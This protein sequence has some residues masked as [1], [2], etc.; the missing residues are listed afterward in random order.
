MEQMR[1]DLDE[2]MSA[3]RNMDGAMLYMSQRVA[4]NEVCFQ[5]VQDSG[6]IHMA[7]MIKK[8]MDDHKKL[9]GQLNMFSMRLAALQNQDGDGESGGSHQKIMGKPSMNKFGS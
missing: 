4:W 7:E 8:V 6:V 2:V 1:K 5:Q 9:Q 3:A